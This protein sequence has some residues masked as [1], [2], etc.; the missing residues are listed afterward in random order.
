MER[1]TI[2]SFVLILLLTAVAIYG[3][4]FQQH[5]AWLT[6]LLFW[7]PEA[8]RN[9]D[10]QLGL[11]L[12]G[13]LQVLMVADLPPGQA[14][15][16]Q[17]METARRIVEKRVNALGL[18]E[19]IVQ[20]QGKDRI[21]V[22]IPGIDNPAQAVDT[23]RETA[24]LEFGE[25][26]AGMTFDS[27]YMLQMTQMPISTT[28]GLSEAEIQAQSAMTGSM[29]FKTVFTGADLANAFVTRDDRTSQPVVAI[30]FQSAAANAF[31][32]YTSSHLGQ[33]LCIVLD[34]QIISCPRIDAVIPNGKATIQGSFTF[35][36]ANQLAVQLQY[37]ALP[38]PLKIESYKAIGPS[39]G[40]ISVEKSI[41]AGVVGLAVV[42]LFMLIYYRLN[43][44]AADL[45]LALY[46]LLNLL[47]YKLVPVT[48]TLP[49][50]AGFLLSAGMAVDANI[51]VFERMKEELR[52]GRSLMR[53]A[54]SGFSRAWTSVRDSNLATLLTCA[55]L[56]IFGNAFAASLVKGFAITLAL[57]TLMNL[58]TAIVV[59]RTLVRVAFGSFGDWIQKHLWVLGL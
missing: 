46:V 22:E 24:L 14:L 54:E 15:E 9:L 10:F 42:F 55:I 49:G 47:L 53:A 34:K 19:P 48:M 1:R 59:T 56:Y 5:P 43:G 7:Q 17:A 4:A 57:G 37:G 50:I 6:N 33:Y 51:L 39:L 31:S 13:G 16:P 23:I 28:Y 45:A 20:I 40:A 52:R 41:R 32:E 18:T 35:D 38:I 29:L 11:D 26:P 8:S 27:I 3:V 44:L 25:P 58:F 12:Q 21:V 30:E 2:I 36:T